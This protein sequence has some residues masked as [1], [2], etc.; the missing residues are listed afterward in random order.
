MQLHSGCRDQDPTN[1]CPPTPY[2][3]VSMAQGPEVLKVRSLTVFSGLKV[4][5]ESYIAPRGPPQCKR[6]QRFGHT[7]CNCGHT[8]R[9]V[10]CGR[11]QLSGER[12]KPKGQPKCRDDD[13]A[14]YWGYVNWKEAKVALAKQASV[15]GQKNAATGRPAA[16]KADRAG[17]SA[18]Q[19]N[20]SMGR[21]HIV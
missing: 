14:N 4:T 10:E 21:N 17:P 11:Y 13:T 12:P 6:C 8:P 16:P 7:Q 19:G 15:R 20:L 18:E 5:V 3:I 1:N 9:C 2:F